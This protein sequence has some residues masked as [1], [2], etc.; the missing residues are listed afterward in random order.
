VVSATQAISD[1]LEGVSP[2]VLSG[3]GGE[4]LFSLLTKLGWRSIIG[5]I[6]KKKTPE[7]FDGNL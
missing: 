4:F 1:A 5:A 2:L 7:W 6:T 3:S